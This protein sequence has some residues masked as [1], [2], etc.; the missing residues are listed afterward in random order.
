[1]AAGPIFFPRFASQY[2]VTLVLG[3][4]DTVQASRGCPTTRVD[5]RQFHDPAP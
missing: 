2:R 5:L 1:M 4:V 3:T